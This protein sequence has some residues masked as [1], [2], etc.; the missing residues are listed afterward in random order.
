MLPI[1][2][3][4]FI[5]K[6]SSSETIAPEDG[7]EMTSKAMNRYVSAQGHF[8]HNIKTGLQR[9]GS[10]ILS[11]HD[12]MLKRTLK[13]RLLSRVKEEMDSQVLVVHMIEEHGTVV[14]PI[15]NGFLERG[16]TVQVRS[17]KGGSWK[18]E[19]FTQRARSWKL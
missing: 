11:F 19:C 9:N 6:I 14:R 1:I 5:I 3:G 7:C 15:R 16:S 10:Q 17:G 8:A 2:N 18:I 12:V 13:Q 4:Y